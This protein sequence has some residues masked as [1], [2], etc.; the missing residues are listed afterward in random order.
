MEFLTAIGILDSS[1]VFEEWKKENRDAFLA[2]GFCIFDNLEDAEW[3][4]GYYVP[5]ADV[6]ATF[7]VSKNITKNPDSPMFRDEEKEKDVKKIDTTQIRITFMEAVVKTEH[8][9][10]QK[11]P[12]HTPQKRFAVLQYIQGILLWNITYVTT[13]FNTLNIKIDAV[14]GNII[15]DELISIFQVQK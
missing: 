11:Y 10:N 9:Q 7:N 1:A 5:S 6:L 3:Q 13:T 8:M 2:N 12:A 15:S 14:T 4:V